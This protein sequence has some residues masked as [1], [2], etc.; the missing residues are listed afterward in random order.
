MNIFNM[1]TQTDTQKVMLT[2]LFRTNQKNLQQNM[3]SKFFCRPKISS[4]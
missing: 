1:G 4:N 3:D 2:Y